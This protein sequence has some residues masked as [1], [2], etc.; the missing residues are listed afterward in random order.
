[1]IDWL[2]RAEG[3]TPHGFCLIW[4]ARLLWLHVASDGLIAL[5]YLS[6]PVLLITVA[7]KRPDLNRYGVLYLFAAFIIGCAATHLIGIVTLWH[8]IYAA[9]GVLKAICAVISLSTAVVLWPMLPRLLRMP[10]P[11]QLAEANSRLEAQA[12]DL[13]RLVAARTA[14]LERRTA[15]FAAACDRAEAAQAVAERE[16]RSRDR[17]LATMSHELRTPLNAVLGFTELLAMRSS[18]GLDD[19]GREYLDIVHEAGRHL[20]SLIND[21]LD[22]QRLAT[23]G[24]PLAPAEIPVIE[25]VR[26]ALAFNQ[27]ALEANDADVTVAVPADLTAHAD[28]RAL[29]QICTNLI[30]NAAKYSHPGGHIRLTARA[31][32]DRVRLEVADEGFGMDDEALDAVFKPF[33]RAHET[34]A[35]IPGTGLGLPTVKLLTEAMSGAVSLA[36]APGAG[37]TATVTLPR[38][39]PLAAPS[40][41]VDFTGRPDREE[42][43]A[44][45]SGA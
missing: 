13:E 27:P 16:S 4:D 31:D 44:R 29:T 19:K 33:H 34:K 10:T 39:A 26:S 11:E 6:I 37:T 3:Y 12:R 18:R 38:H 5:A 32:G 42:P 22:Y 36:S 45:A 35:T 23:T 9:S 25:V 28:R 8:P 20:L 40:P 15:D 41:A 17:F 1:M 14:D 43:K 7:R 24:V 21:V 2:F 30:G